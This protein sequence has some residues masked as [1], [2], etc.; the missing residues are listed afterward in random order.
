MNDTLSICP[1][2]GETMNTLTEAQ[3]KI[4]GSQNC[5]DEPML[6][7]KTKNLHAVIKSLDKLRVAFEKELVKDFGCDQYVK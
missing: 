7:I 5:C 4:F 6:R 2:C 3:V 1:Y